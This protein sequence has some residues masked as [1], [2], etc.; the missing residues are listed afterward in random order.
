MNH[1]IM[2]WAL[3]ALLWAIYALLWAIYF[4]I[5]RE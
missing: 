1:D 4:K 5:P 3:Y 2:F